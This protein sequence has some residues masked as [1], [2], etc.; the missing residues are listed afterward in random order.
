MYTCIP[1][2]EILE[3]L[4]VQKPFAR[5]GYKIL[6]VMEALTEECTSSGECEAA[7]RVGVFFSR[8]RLDKNEKRTTMPR[9]KITV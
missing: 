1:H 6:E 3:K 9:I 8:I 5:M 2:T 4:A 7:K